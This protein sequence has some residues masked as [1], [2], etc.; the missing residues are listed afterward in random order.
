MLI[1]RDLEISQLDKLLRANK[2][3]LVV[4][5]SSKPKLGRSTFLEEIRRLATN[6]NWHVFPLIP[7]GQ[8]K[9]SGTIEIDRN[10]TK[11]V[12][13]RKVASASPVR[14][15]TEDGHVQTTSRCP[16]SFVPEGAISG[17]E[18]AGIS[19]INVQGGVLLPSGNQQD[20]LS[21]EAASTSVSM[22][23]MLKN[24]SA[25]TVTGTLILISPYQ[26]DK[27]FETWF[28]DSY[29]PQTQGAVSP[30]VLIVA[31]YPRELATL[32]TKADLSI[33]LGDLPIQATREYFRRLNEDI[34]AKMEKDE[35]QAYANASAKS[36]QLIDA[37]THL[38]LLR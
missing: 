31:G 28:M 26:P 32:T 22:K 7:P 35:I 17:V 25:A 23:P 10:T 33:D 29:V 38:L 12:F 8:Q 9:T 37:F 1:G 27:E 15:S 3:A 16:A 14:I 13:L 11:D 20:G 5:S 6:Q 21:G 4:V 34:Q 18:S 2:Q 24:E 19:S 30:V 36:P